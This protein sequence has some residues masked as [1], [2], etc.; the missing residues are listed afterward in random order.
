MGDRCVDNRIILKSFSNINGRRM[1]KGFMCFRIETSNS[2]FDIG[3]EPPFRKFR[4][5][6]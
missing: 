1:W 5:I 6:F 4:K 3:N 2:F